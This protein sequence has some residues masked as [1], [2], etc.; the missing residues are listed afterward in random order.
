MLVG[1]MNSIYV[2]LEHGN[3]Y[4][5]ADDSIRGVSERIFDLAISDH[6]SVMGS[7]IGEAM[8]ADIQDD[9]LW[10][11]VENPNASIVRTVGEFSA[12]NALMGTGEMPF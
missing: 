11:S 10:L 5:C 4:D 1:T 9:G 3:A 8:L 7:M 2:E 12:N 6:A